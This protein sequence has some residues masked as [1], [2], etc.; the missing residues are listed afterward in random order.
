VGGS[1]RWAR[2]GGRVAAGQGATEAGLTS[3][4]GCRA[5]VCRNLDT[6]KRFMAAGTAAGAASGTRA[7]ALR[8]TAR[9]RDSRR[10]RP[11]PPPAARGHSPKPIAALSGLSGHTLIPL[12]LRAHGAGPTSRPIAARPPLEATP[13]CRR[14]GVPDREV[15]CGELSAPGGVG[16]A[17]PWTTAA[18]SWAG[19]VPGRLSRVRGTPFSGRRESRNELAPFRR[20]GTLSGA[21][22]T[23]SQG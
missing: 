6:L 22:G 21:A 12:S 23:E 9:S 3:R 13:Q 11:H 16:R 17:G 7:S 14:V 2:G 18:I 8:C 10:L 4:R 20:Q 15:T 1:P 5:S 19:F